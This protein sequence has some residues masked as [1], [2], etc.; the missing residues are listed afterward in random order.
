M[1]LRPDP[2]PAIPNWTP[3]EALTVETSSPSSNGNGNG[4]HTDDSSSSPQIRVLEK[5]NGAYT[6]SLDLSSQGKQVVSGGVGWQPE[7]SSETFARKRVAEFLVGRVQEVGV[8]VVFVPANPSVP[9]REFRPTRSFSDELEEEKG[10]KEKTLVISHMSST[11]FSTL[12]WTPSAEHALKV[13]EEEGQFFV[14]DKD[15]F[16]RIFSSPSSPSILGALKFQ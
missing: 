8:E 7:S 13:G 15:L 16:L 10:K 1:F 6:L 14:N 12:F 11:V 5:D 4:I 9:R 3:E 2:R